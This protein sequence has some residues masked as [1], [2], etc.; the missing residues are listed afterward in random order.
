MFSLMETRAWQRIDPSLEYNPDNLF[1]NNRNFTFS[2]VYEH[3]LRQ[4]STT[5][6]L[7]AKSKCCE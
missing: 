4:L 3:M 2:T 5:V 6:G 7:T 1:H